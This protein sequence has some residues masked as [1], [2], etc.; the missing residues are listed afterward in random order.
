VPGAI[1][2]HLFSSTREM[3]LQPPALF[4]IYDEY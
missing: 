2:G 3:D 1:A 4:V